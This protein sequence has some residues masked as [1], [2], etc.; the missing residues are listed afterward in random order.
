MYDN[1]LIVF[2]KAA[3]ALIKIFQL[4]GKPRAAAAAASKGHIARILL[5]A[6]KFALPAVKRMGAVITA[7]ALLHMLALNNNYQLAHFILP[8][9]IRAERRPA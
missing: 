7:A 3:Q 4:H 6:G 8:C 2:F 1:L 9:R 5:V